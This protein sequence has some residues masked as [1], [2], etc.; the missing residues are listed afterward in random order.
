MMDHLKLLGLLLNIMAGVL[1]LAYLIQKKKQAVENVLN[2]LI[3]YSSA[4]VLGIT[5]FFTAIYLNLNLPQLSGSS[6]FLLPEA[7]VILLAYVV[8]I[9]ASYSV[10]LISHRLING[11]IHPGLKTAG[12]IM[13][14]I[15]I[16]SFIPYV[17]LPAQSRLQRI[18]DGIVENHAV[19]FMAAEVFFLI[20]LLV[21]SRKL[22]GREHKSAARSFS[23][24]FMGRY[25][26]LPFFTFLVP[27]VARGFFFFIYWHGSCFV[28]VKYF[29]L[30]FIGRSEDRRDAAAVSGRLGNKFGLSPREREILQLML[31]GKNNRE[32]EDV[33]FISY[34]TVKN[35][36]HA[37]YG[38]IGVKNRY[39]LFKLVENYK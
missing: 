14:L 17:L 1:L 9:T 13:I 28:W 35:H 27:S 6:P 19:V 31:L 39:Q 20:R 12:L 26:L 38:K 10:I 24:L 25:F 33:L 3:I 5:L 15:T 29:Y 4:I 16:I 23:L 18:A 34:N 37:I 30:P 36:I 32:I 2:S 11:R 21:L 8:I 22:E 7:G